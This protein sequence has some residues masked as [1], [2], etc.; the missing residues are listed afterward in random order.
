MAQSDCLIIGSGIAGLA[1]AL[2]LRQHGLTVTLLERQAT[3][4]EASWAGGGI[5]CPLYGWRY[6]EPVMRLAALGMAAYPDF[7]AH[8]SQQ[9]QVDPEFAP[10]GM[11]ILDPLSPSE[12]PSDDLNGQPADIED[13]SSRYGI[14]TTFGS[15]RQ[16]FPHL[17]DAPALWLPDIH[18]VRNPR[19]LKALME[20]ARQAGVHIVTETPAQEILVDRHRVTGV[21]TATNTLHAKQVLVTAGAWSGALMPGLTPAKVFPVRGQM[22]RF[23]ASPATGLATTLMDESVYLIPR[24]DGSVVVGSTVE[25]V[26]FDKHNTEEAIHHLHRKA[27][28]LWPNLDHT[29]LTH[30]WSGLRPGTADEIPYI[31]AHPD[32]EGLFI[33]TGFYRNGLAMAPAVADLVADLM[34]GRQPAIDLTDYRLDRPAI[35]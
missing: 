30:Q 24:R 19:L 25:H 20:A 13:W 21:R 2:K 3:A 23:D 15:A 22:L 17:P 10:G 9:S 1:T 5:L 34:V 18:T 6:P 31:G 29:P 32:I 7:V 8:L 27:I 35:T 33:S 16:Y 28:E 11:L 26:G 14:T 12:N 4:Q